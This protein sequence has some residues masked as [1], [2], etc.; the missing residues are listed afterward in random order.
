VSPRLAGGRPSFTALVVDDE[1]IARS[2]L[3]AMLVRHPEVRVVGEAATGIEAA[4]VAQAVRPDVLFL[5]VRMPDRNGIELLKEW[6]DRARPA[7]VFVT[8]HAD[9]ALEA[10]GLS[11]VDYLLKPFSETRLA[12]TVRRLV[13]FLHGA[14]AGVVGHPLQIPTADAR[15]TRRLAVRDGD[16]LLFVE[17]AEIE[18]LEV[19]GN[20]LQAA[21]G[22]RFY[23][24]RGTLGE[25]SARLQQ[26]SFVR[27][28]RSVMVNWGCIRTAEWCE[29]GQCHL[30]MATGAA[31]RSSRRYRR[32]VRAALDGD[33]RVDSARHRVGRPEGTGS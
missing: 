29:N 19:I 30:E 15:A 8:A 13:R 18:W 10:F 7:V 4:R 3:C 32:D 17:P 24:L 22:G 16:R 12:D 1:R 26:A 5:D 25:L 20:Y 9:Y 14:N 2:G 31:L 33:D 6:P 11:A 27:I 28:S 23:V 21:V